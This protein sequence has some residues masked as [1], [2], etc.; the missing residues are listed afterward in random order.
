MTG[1]INNSHDRNN[2]NFLLSCSR[3]ELQNWYEKC[4]EDDL[5]YAQSLLDAF[6]LELAEKAKSL[7]IENCL[8]NL[9]CFVEA[10]AVLSCVRE[11][12]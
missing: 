1:L 4:T 11:I 10:N 6:D 3:E 12:K 9:K 2:L 8:D 5:I 7:D